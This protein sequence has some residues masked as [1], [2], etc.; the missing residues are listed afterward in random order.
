[1][2]AYHI[3][4]QSSGQHDSASNRF[5]EDYYNSKLTYSIRHLSIVGNVTQENLT[6]AIKKSLQICK[7]I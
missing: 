3:T 4:H 1:M 2:K 6:D 7:L 5:E